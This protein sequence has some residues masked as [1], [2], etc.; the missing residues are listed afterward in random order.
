MDGDGTQ[1]WA[2]V[3]L[4]AVWPFGVEGRWTVP[5]GYVPPDFCLPRSPSPRPAPRTHF[6]LTLPIAPKVYP[7]FFLFF[8]SSCVII[9]EMTERAL[10]RTHHDLALPKACICERYLRN[11]AFQVRQCAA[12]HPAPR[13]QYVLCVCHWD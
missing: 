10:A 4:G 13:Y 5:P 11:L 6:R 7:L 3:R 12:L 8:F 1:A 2:N 9:Y